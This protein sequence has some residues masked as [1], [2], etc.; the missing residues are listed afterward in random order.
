MKNRT[1]TTE[2]GLRQLD[3]LPATDAVVLA[4]T[5]P[6]PAPLHHKMMRQVVRDAMPVLARSLDRA[7]RQRVDS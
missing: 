3:D 6:G 7:A 2:G 1:P 4:W 5:T